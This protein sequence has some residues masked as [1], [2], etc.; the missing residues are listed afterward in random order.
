MSAENVAIVKSSW[1]G[2]RQGL[3]EQMERDLAEGLP[4]RIESWAE[5]AGRPALQPLD[6]I[7]GGD[8]VLVCAMPEDG[9]RP[10][11]FNYTLEG[12]RIVGWDVFEDE[13]KARAAAGLTT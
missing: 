12:P 7:D 10:L 11:W 2:W 3:R 4:E 8:V 6:F 5:G 9:D 1:A 13:A